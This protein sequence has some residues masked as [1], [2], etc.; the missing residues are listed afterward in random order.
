MVRLAVF[1]TLLFSAH[2]VFPDT[3]K[4]TVIIG[5][6]IMWGVGVEETSN[7]VAMRLTQLGEKVVNISS[8]GAGIT[9]NNLGAI[10]EYLDG[11]YRTLGN[12][13]IQIGIND[14]GE[15]VPTAEFSEAY[16]LFL[17]EVAL[18]GANLHCTLLPLNYGQSQDKVNAKGGTYIEYLVAV[19]KQCLAHNGTFLNISFDYYDYP[20]GDNIHLN[21]SGHAK[22]TDAILLALH[23][24]ATRDNL[25]SLGEAIVMR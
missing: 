24:I 4:S 11:T 17:D 2:T 9:G 8:P 23:S 3:A 25:D 10:I 14:W 12:V 16:G 13:I 20:P 1:L 19:R 15:G 18:T 21:D 5:D 6:S 7:T 22:L